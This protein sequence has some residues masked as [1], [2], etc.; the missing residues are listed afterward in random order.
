MHFFVLYYSKDMKRIRSH[1]GFSLVELLVVISI[2]ALLVSF[3]I[4]SF[5]SS[6]LRSRDSQ[7]VAYVDQINTALELYYTHNG[8]Y[9]TLITAGQALVV[10][11]I[12]YL[13]SVPSNPS[14]RTDGTCHNTDFLYSTSANNTSYTLVFCLGNATGNYSAGQ[15]ACSNGNCTPYSQPDYRVGLTNEWIA[16]SGITS[17]G[18]L[19]S[20]WV[21]SIGSVAATQG[22]DAQKPTITGT[23]SGYNYV[24]FDGNRYLTFSTLTTASTY[25]VFIV[26]K[27]DDPG[28]S[29]H[30]DMM[31]A[32]NVQ[33][34][35][36]TAQ[37]N[38]WSYGEFDAGATHIRAVTYSAG[39]ITNWHIRVFQPTHLFSNGTEATYISSGN[40][41][42][43][44]LNR[45]GVRQDTTAQ[46]FIG[47]IADIRI[48]NTVL[49]PTDRATVEN[50]LNYKYQIY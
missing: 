2:I 16:D 40:L 50:F 23:I 24:L 7:R 42:A 18:G 21:D 17:S 46:T 30:L 19:V 25:T 36:A 47:K 8:I 12:T 32:G 15:M 4:I 43:M 11:G 5:N 33:G 27:S 20:S 39:D 28:N 41:S 29:G 9:P 44:A 35:F 38:G 1:N 13:T 22:T 48:Y 34:L 14:P 3:S 45:I 26:Y 49:S 10:N 37:P 31:L 6:R